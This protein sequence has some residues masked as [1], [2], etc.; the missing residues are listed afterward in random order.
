MPDVSHP[1]RPVRFTNNPWFIDDPTGL[2]V[3]FGETRSR[4][5]GLVNALAGKVRIGEDDVVCMF[6]PN[7]VDYPITMWV[8]HR[9]EPLLATSSTK[10][11]QRIQ[12]RG[13]A[14][15]S[16]HRYML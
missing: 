10:I 11:L 12:R 16:F 14:S 8:I 9:L 1:L 7:Y 5:Y 13:Q 4:V 6:T 2:E 15:C 3:N